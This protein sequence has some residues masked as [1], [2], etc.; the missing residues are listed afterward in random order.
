MGVTCSISRR[1]NGAILQDVAQR[2]APIPFFDILSKACFHSLIDFRDKT[3]AF[4][5]IEL[6]FRSQRLNSKEFCIDYMISYK[7]YIQLV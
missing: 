6:P 3:Y 2:I 4:S 5:I 1:N 7:R